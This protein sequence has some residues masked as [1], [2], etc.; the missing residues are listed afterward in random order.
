MLFG[1]VDVKMVAHFLHTMRIVLGWFD[2]VSNCRRSCSVLCEGFNA[3]ADDDDV[4]GVVCVMWCPVIID[5][6]LVCATH[7]SAMC[8]VESESFVASRP[9]SCHSSL[10]WCTRNEH[11]HSHK[12][13]PTGKHI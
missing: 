3:A 11:T 12:W 1:R 8:V 2:F 4:F 5:L 13:A 10:A 7:S 9:R 6:C